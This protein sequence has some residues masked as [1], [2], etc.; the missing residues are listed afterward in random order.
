VPE[1][2]NDSIDTQVPI[3]RNDGANLPN[4]GNVSSQRAA[5]KAKADQLKKF[6]RSVYR[7]FDVVKRNA[8]K[9][10]R[11]YHFRG[12]CLNSDVQEWLDLWEAH[13]NIHAWDAKRKDQSSSAEAI[14][15]A[16][17]VVLSYMYRLRGDTS[18][19]SPTRDPAPP[20]AIMTSPVFTRAAGSGRSRRRGRDL[21]SDSDSDYTERHQHAAS[22]A[23][24]DNTI[25][26]NRKRRFRAVRNTSAA[27]EPESTSVRNET[28]SDQNKRRRVTE[29]SQELLD[30][31]EASARAVTPPSESL[32]VRI[33]VPPGPSV[34]QEAD[35]RA[36]EMA[37][38]N[39]ERP[40]ARSL[41]GSVWSLRSGPE[42]SHYRNRS[43]LPSTHDTDTPSLQ[44]G[45]ATPLDPLE[46]SLDLPAALPVAR[47]SSPETQILKHDSDDTSQDQAEI[48]LA[49]VDI[50]SAQEEISSLQED[51]LSVPDNIPSA[52]ELEFITIPDDD[53]DLPSTF[54]SRAA[55][56][57][58]N[59]DNV[60]NNSANTTPQPAM[61]PN[62]GDH[63]PATPEQ[64]AGILP[65]ARL[66]PPASPVH[67]PAKQS[68]PTPADAHCLLHGQRLLPRS[69]ISRL[70]R[71][72]L[73]R[74]RNLFEIANITLQMEEADILNDEA[75]FN[76]MVNSLL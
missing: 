50:L 29:E 23:P 52:R 63:S 64:E 71:I 15:A 28:S 42:S 53:E 35:E 6:R 10:E 24:D 33:R 60:S 36:D 26:I 13:E 74:K 39:D 2:V 19:V 58:A 72:A 43:P 69:S 34:T 9:L 41:T 40:D 31:V 57:S 75:N 37:V 12:E 55:A 44:A 73:E 22:Y 20:M 11:R 48:P 46:T 70:E 47:A 59:E 21:Y 62:N 68:I 56:T 4:N 3:Q 38:T 65:G 5:A 51:V 27:N 32:V 49:Q 16:R 1:Q 7:K 61:L 30:I 25:V 54:P 8:V 66:T 67:G 18:S 17:Q 45:S 76:S 14:E